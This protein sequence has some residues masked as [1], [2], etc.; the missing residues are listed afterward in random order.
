MWEPYAIV[1]AALVATGLV[2]MRVTDIG[3]WYQALNKPSWQPP[4]WAFGPIW[5]TIYVFI[6]ASVGRVW[7]LLGADERV[8]FV[9]LM[10]VNA[11]LNIA[12]SY[13][14]F[15]RRRP[16]W[17]L[18][19]IVPLWLSILAI[20]VFVARHD[21]LAAWMIAPYASWVLIAGWLNFTMVRMNPDAHRS[22][23][24]PS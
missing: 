5:T 3:P 6:G 15:K 2:G 8:P 9:V 4:D 16:V 20:A 7:P 10:I 23:P 22:V 24:D 13:L 14:F 17:S 18:I 1:A 11:A 21:A 19:E 12:W